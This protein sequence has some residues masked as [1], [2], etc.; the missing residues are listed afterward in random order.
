MLRFVSL[1]ALIFIILGS[2]NGQTVIIS[3]TGNGGFENG[4]TLAA[5]GWLTPSNTA[6]TNKFFVGT[7]GVPSAGANCAY[8]S[9]NATG[10]TYNYALT[11]SSTFLFYRDVTFPA[12]ETDIRLTFKWKGQGEGNF[13]YLTVFSMPTTVTPLHNSPAGGSQSWLNIPTAYSGAVVHCS[14]QNLNLQSS[15]QTQSICLPSSYAGTTRR[16]VFMWS[17]DNSG[18]SQSPAAV[19]EISLVSQATVVP[20]SQPTALNLTPAATTVT[21]NFTG[22]TP[23]SSGYLVVRTNNATPPSAPSDNTTYTAGQSAL[24]G[25]IVSSGSTTSFTAT[26]LSLNTA[27]FF[28]VFAYNGVCQ[29][30]LYNSVSPLSGSSTT[31]DCTLSGTK[32]VGTTGDYASITAALAAA[33]SQGLASSVIF[34]LQPS[35]LSTAEPAFPV[36]IPEILC[37]GASRTI[38][39]RPQA[40]AASLSITS[41]STTGT[42]QMNGADYVIFDGR[43]GGTGTTSQLTITNTSTSGYTLQFINGATNNTVRYCNISGVNSGTA[44]GVVAFTTTNTTAGNSSNL[45]DFCDFTAG[46]TTPTNLVYSSG[47]TATY[48]VQNNNNTFSN[49]TFRNWFSATLTNWAINIAGG[50]SDWTIN[51]NSFFQ[52]ATRTYT[53]TSAT[54]VGAIAVASTTNGSNFTITNNF[55]GGSAANCGGTPMTYTGGTTGT[56]TPRFIRFSSSVGAY[57]NINNNTIANISVTTS[58][59]STSSGLITHLNGNVNINNNT[60]GSMS[61]TGSIT[62]SLAATSTA[63]FFLP[64]SVG[65]GTTA[66][67]IVANNNQIGGITVSTTSTGAVSFRIM[68][69]QPVAGSKV[70]FSGNTIGGT[71]ANS[72]QQLTNSQVVGILLVNPSTGGV[73]TNNTIRNITGTNTGTTLSVRGIDVQGAGGGHTI[74]DNTVFNLST[75]SGNISINNSASVV[76]INMTASVLGGNVVSGN[77]VHSLSNTSTTTAAWV[78]GITVSAPASPAAASPVTRNNIHSL[79]TASATAG[80]AGIFCLSVGGN[81]PVTN[82][83]IRLGINSSGASVTTSSQING[84]YKAATVSQNISFNTVYI[85]GSTVVS[86]TVSTFAFRRSASGTLDTVTN[87]IFM[88]ARSNTSGTGKHYAVSLNANTA[89][90]SNHNDLF[91]NGTGG[92]L[93]LLGSTDYTTLSAW[94]TATSQDFSSISSDPKLINPA[95]SSTAVDLH[96]QPTVSTGIERGGYAI[97]YVTVDYDNQTRS[98]LTPVDIGADAGDFVLSDESGPAIYYSPLSLTTCNTSNQTISGV[99]ITDGTGVPLSGSL[100]PRIYYRKGSGSWFS[101]PGTLAGGV[102]TNSTW[103]FTI[104][105]SDMGGLVTGDVVSYYIIAQDVNTP[106][107]IAS[108]SVGAIATDVNT[109]TSH[110]AATNNFTITTV[111]AG[112]YTVGTGGDFSTLTAAVNSYN[113]ACLN[114]PVTFSLTNAYSSSGETFP[115]TINANTAASSTNTLTIKPASGMVTVSGSLASGALVRL[116]GA[117][118][119]IIDGSTGGGTDRSLTITNTATTAPAG[120]WISST[121][122]GAGAT[123]NS[124]RNCIINT[125]AATTAT[126]YGIS[127]SGATVGSAGADNDNITIQNNLITST[128][129]GVQANGFA[130]VSAG[131]LD[132]LIISGNTFNSVSTST[133][134]TLIGVQLGNALGSTISQNTLNLSYAAAGQPV[135]ISLETGVSGALVTRNNITRVTTTNSGGYGGRGITVG[136][137]SATSN[138]TISNNNIS[139]VSGSNWSAFGNS[140]SMGIAI[141]IIG[142]SSTLSTVAGGINLYHNTVNMFDSYSSTTNCLTTALYVGSGASALDIRNNIFVNSMNNGGT[143][144][145]SKNFAIYSVAA[146][147]A[148]SNI[149]NNDYFVSGSQGVL[150]YLVSDQS[151]LAALTTAFGGNANS[152]SADPAFNSNSNLQPQPGSPVLGAG[153]VGTGVTVD[154]T[155]ATRGTPPAIGSYEVPLDGVPPV[156]TYVPIPNSLCSSAPTL[157]VTITDFSGVNTA[158]GTSPRLYYKKSADANTLAGNTSADNGWKFVESTSSSSPFSFV[159]DATLLQSPIAAGDNIQYFV[160]AQD[161]A[162]TPNFSANVATF[163]TAPASVALTG[164]SFPVSGTN[165]YSVLTPIATSVTI[166]ATGTYPTLT[167]AGGLFAAINA[168]GLS[169][170]TTVTIIDASV[171]ETGANALNQIA[172]GCS[173]QATLTIKPQTTSTLTGSVASGALIKLNG[174]D[175]I[176]IDGSNSGGTDRSLTISNT[177]ASAPTAIW[178]AS[179]GPGS[180]ATNNI[181]RNCIINASAATSLTAYGISVSGATIGS[182]G[183]DNDNITI[184]NNLITSTN[185]GVQAN[186][187]AAVSSGGLDNLVIS[188]NTFNSVSSTTLATLLGIQLGNALGS[189]ISQNTLS[190]TYAAD[191]QPVG[192]SLE[193]GVS[194]ALVTRNNITRVFT[195]STLGYAGRGITVGTGSTASNITISNNNI[196]GVGGSNWSSF[197]NSSSIGI[198]IGIVGN[199]TTLTATTGGVNL[200]HNSVNMSDSYSSTTNCITTALYVG[201]G[202]SNLDI[203]NNIFVNSMNNTGSGTTSRNYA[204]YSAA[205]NAAFANIN[206]NNYS[207]SGTQGTLAFLGSNRNNMTALR[208]ATAQDVNSLSSPP[209]FVSSTDLHLNATGNDCLDKRGTPIAAVTTD[210]DGASRDASLPDIGMDE[211]TSATDFSIQVSESSELTSN[212]GRVCAGESAVLTAS[213]GTAYSWS[214]GAN[215][216]S[217]TVNPAST[218]TYTV[219]ITLNGCTVTSSYTVATTALP[220]PSISFAET[221]GNNPDDGVICVGNDVTISAAGGNSYSWNGGSTTSSISVTPS[222]NTTYTVSIVDANNCTGT[223]TAAVTVNALP[224]AAITF[225]ETSGNNPDDGTICTGASVVLNASGGTGYS[226]DTGN[227]TASVTVSPTAGTTYTVTVT[228]GNACVTSTSTSVVVNSLQVPTTTVTDNSGNTG[229]DGVICAGDQATLTASAGSGYLWQTS[230]T[231]QSVAV[232]PAATT[233]Y[234]VIVTDINGCQ[235]VAS[236]TVTVNQLP[237]PQVGFTENT[238]NTPNDGIICVGDAVTLSV[239]GMVSYA[240]NNNQTTS[241]ITVSPSSTTTYTV[242]VTDSN[243]CNGVSTAA[244]NVNTLPI[245]TITADESSG[246]ADDDGIICLGNSVTLTGGGGISYVWSTSESTS[247]VTVSPSSG[248]TYTVTAKDQNACLASTSYSITVDPLPTPSIAVADNSGVLNDGIVLIGASATLTASGGTSYLWDTGATTAAVTVTPDSTTTYTVTVT[249]ANACSAASTSTVTVVLEQLPIIAVSETSGNNNNDGN[250]CTGASV[251]IS[252]SNGESFVWST[253]SST[254]AITVSPTATTTYT[255]TATDSFGLTSTASTTVTVFALPTPSVSVADNSGVTVNDGII[256]TGASAVITAS[257]GVSYLWNTG[258][259]TASI[260]V[261]PTATTTYTVTVTNENGCSATTTRTITVNPLPTP[262]IAVTETSGVTNND[263]TVCLGASASLAASGGTSYLWA[264]G[265]TT[266]SITVT[267]SATTTYTVT[268]TNANGCTATSTRTITVNDLPSPSVS[269]TD[270]SGV[271]SN[272]GIICIGASATLAAT[273]GASYVWNTNATTASVTV[274]PTTTTTYTVT[275]TNSNLCSAS[276]TRTVTVN[277]LPTPSVSVAETSGLLNNDGTICA[278]ANAVLTASGGT[279]YVWSNGG[280]TASVTVSPSTT[281]TYTVTATNSNGCTATSTRTVTVTPLPTPSI[282]IVET[283][284]SNNNDGSICIGAGASLTSSGGTSYS[285]SNGSASA[286][287]T[288]SPSATTTYTV[289]VTNANGCTTATST[290]ITVNPLPVPVITVAETSGLQNN[291]AVICSGSPAVLTASGG[292]AYLW[293]NGGTSAAITVTPAATAAYSVTV[294]SA[295]GCS[296]VTSVNITV[297][298][299][300]VPVLLT[301]DMSGLL[302]D[303][304]IICSGATAT[305]SASGGS[306]YLW[307]NG[308]SSSSVSVSPQVTTT[309]TVTVTSSDAC[310]STATRTV[311][312]NALPVPSFSYSETSGLTNNDGVI[313]AG[314]SVMI[315]A[316]GGTSYAWNT[317]GATSTITVSPSATTTYTVTVTNANGCPAVANSAVTV[318]TVPVA[319]I[320]VTEMSGAADNDGIILI[321][322]SATLAASGGTSYNWNTGAS[323]SVITVTPAVTT[324][325]TVTV[326]NSNGCTSTANTTITASLQQMPVITVTETSGVDNNDGIICAGASATLSV[327]GGTSYLWNNGSTSNVLVVSP[328]VTTTY[329]VTD[330]DTRG[331]T[332]STSVTIVVNSLPTPSV[333]TA[334]TSGVASNDGIICIGASVTL[335]ASGGTSY[336]WSNGGIVSSF[337][338]S[339]SSTTTFTV[340]V[341]NAN[342]CTASTSVTINVNPL[343]APSVAVAESSGVGNNDAITCSGASA[344]LTASGGTSYSWNTGGTTAAITVAPTTTTTYTVTVTNAN[345]CS[346][347]AT[348]TISVT[349]LP[350]PLISATETSGVAN[351]DGIVCIGASAT[352][353]AT[354]GATYIWNDGSTTASILV[355]PTST[356]TYTVTATNANNCSATATFVVTVNPLPSPVISVAETS[357]LASNDG[358]IC[359]GASTTL[360][361]SGGTAYSWSNGSATAAITVSPSV[362]TSYTVTVTNANGCSATRAITI[363]VNTL[364]VASL[365]VSETSGSTNNDGNICLGSSA[366]L[367]A[368]GGT[369]YVWSNGLTAAII[370]VTPSVTTTYTVT[371]SNANGCTTTATTTVTVFFPPSVTAVSTVCAPTASVI[372]LTGDFFTGTSQVLMNGTNCPSFTVISATQINVSKPFSGPIQSVS[373]TNTCG[374]TTYQANVSVTSFSPSAGQPGTIV[375]ITGV[376]MACLQSVTIG[377]VPQIILANNDNSARVFIMPGSTTGPITV[378]STNNSTA[379]SA[380]TYTVS[381]T[382]NPYVQQGG[383]QV[384]GSAIGNAQQGTSVAV[385]SDGNTAVIGGPFD[386]T[387]KG[388]AWIYVRNGTTWSQQGGK[389]VGTGAVGTARQGTAVAISAEGNTVAVGG[390][391]DNTSAGA[392]WIFTRSSG[393]WSQQGNKLTG[394]GATG[395]AQQGSSLSLSAS[396]DILAVGGPAD[397]MFGGA[398]WVFAR[399]AGAWTQE[400]SKLVGTGMSGQAR[401]G[402]SVAVSSDGTTLIVGGNNDMNRR[403]AAWIFTRGSGSW[404]QQGNKLIGSSSSADAWQGISVAISA[405]GNTALVGGSNDNSLK[406]SVWVF[407][408]SSGVW[409]QLGS[410]LS[411]TGAVGSSRQGSSVGLSADGNTVVIGGAGDDSNKGAI[412]VFKRNGS[413]FTQQGSKVSGS[414]ATGSARQG[415]SISVSSNGTTAALGG[416]A[417]NTNK[418]A[419]WFF[420]PNASFA[421]TKTD[422]RTPDVPVSET[423]GFTLQQNIPN[424]LTDRTTVGF[425]LPEACTAEWQITDMSGR[426]VLSLKREYP[427]GNNIEIFDLNAYQGVY[428]YTLKTPFGSRTRKMVVVVR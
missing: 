398:T 44:N 127:V 213:N 108:N 157:T 197:G 19:D 41:S 94:T 166:G 388:S 375:D 263:G 360:T 98:G 144:T 252:A 129:V 113:G 328:S 306:S 103:N 236:A 258:G 75:N 202:A 73:F 90:L 316:S 181:V 32:S 347:T 357:G 139:G 291:D 417:D 134:A 340:T 217:A 117:D 419:F 119:V 1:I 321:G 259:N 295:A 427:A 82:N 245:P 174:A 175:N 279:S 383:K 60:L 93:G 243:G 223:S 359:V 335:S 9:D 190:L 184:Q 102:A 68:Y 86:G 56:I 219:T 148:Y 121:G 40:G 170:N 283:S 221:S 17:N 315:T 297:N 126:A 199:A 356:T 250:I 270:N 135:G 348:R 132:N 169:D 389:L 123:N 393:V 133:L 15:Y 20:S 106:A 61:A 322:D 246:L 421:D 299:L 301:S 278:G 107:R 208:T 269:A 339:P 48:N 226:W 154:Y 158:S 14:P 10:T 163:T 191:G 382:P 53:G 114:G 172:Y 413:T 31:T 428:Y 146:N 317:G 416:P 401:Q 366:V 43:P 214:S 424:P 240:W 260:T 377:G 87:N 379:A 256:C 138:I 235:G 381:A 346:A 225:T 412:W 177:A 37:T 80:M 289:T 274:S 402:V 323:T 368:T 420:V 35:Y 277:P 320:A 232:S 395:N 399:S 304:G 29:G 268:V 293:S 371:V 313:C 28:W 261:S 298:P 162:A 280:T 239:S 186:G 255:V 319:S 141:G 116:N 305:I 354:G 338:V 272:D 25:V 285:W 423:A 12:G 265:A 195:S 241:S 83:M 344:I 59:V 78:N 369:A 422:V 101:Q 200:Y 292:S 228:D 410:K 109:V 309:Y 350:A 275:A 167:G 79:S 4:S 318:N 76:G 271:Q 21:G 47:S 349:P 85:G 227:N 363:T 46:A 142:N 36:V 120:I 426:V 307:S 38:T 353:T 171:T 237:A 39:I 351:N 164:A 397:N 234:T 233:S 125:N 372:T 2:S 22:T 5:N 58:S 159:I 81:S 364:P 405:D 26:G 176:I 325:Y 218:S 376:N 216:A 378:T 384:G 150:G 183:A 24:G 111:L 294:T 91:V 145:A 249:N 72:I 326:T 408:R 62:F 122:A 131:G 396:G 206:F 238:G 136:T 290:T 179:T 284:G 124:I 173:G 367:I 220:V 3:P 247:S 152:I 311:T 189:S 168:G 300:P 161:V 153:T 409:S 33:S 273:G 332:T 380:A 50:N 327:A 312:V 329:T 334:E 406:G 89:L 88:N 49:S 194:G 333:A 310:V 222:T 178:I 229:N 330:T 196:S 362:T 128:N 415:T 281:T 370:T 302:N 63:P 16:L 100:V 324:T 203:R 358:I 118:F 187:S 391:L 210:F 42:I 345:G 314:S 403:G 341:T 352:L 8:V 182:A 365:S 253:G 201:S 361:A 264:N 262:S 77:T 192:I 96:I 411:G 337:T 97:S 390:P 66:S 257:G 188:G 288:V 74:S 11:A 18:G 248:A 92:V 65:T 54:D 215:T 282:A 407:T 287:I 254:S 387:N 230:E 149:N 67:T 110:P 386:D 84:I 385:S 373:V 418:G 267:P 140:S 51:N 155:G 404:S 99:V 276:T 69:A 198:G 355:M 414:G 71:V 224:V 212:D 251:T 143:G 105:V 425:D 64:I 205:T 57:S 336:S 95:G 55:I 400:G 7:V 286:S 394:T 27:Y 193:T 343:P 211:F 374:T 180:G 30:P 303:D 52:T 137:G 165:S 34:E 6:P 156:I 308:A 342:G 115:I 209:S 244:V 231:T 160:V 104:V 204:L 13:D 185:V 266:T 151:T 331:N 23:A 70:T 130:A 147:T 207:V 296:A 45:F 392:V 112:T 242:S